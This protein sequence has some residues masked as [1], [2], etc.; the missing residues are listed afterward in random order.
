MCSHISPLCISEGHGKYLCIEK[1][2]DLEPRTS[3]M[4]EIVKAPTRSNSLAQLTHYL[5]SHVHLRT[6]LA[7]YLTGFPPNGKTLQ[8]SE[9]DNSR[10]LHSRL[11][12]SVLRNHILRR[13]KHRISTVL[14]Q[15]REINFSSSHLSASLRSS[16]RLSMLCRLRVHCYL[17]AFC[18]TSFSAVLDV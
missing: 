8:F 13:R 11:R 3:C 4:Q 10:F 18:R 17:T 2:Q 1:V 7:L 5:N 16:R 12:A 14:K 15:L 6:V 9:S